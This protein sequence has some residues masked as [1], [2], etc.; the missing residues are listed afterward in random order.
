M[1]AV[2]TQKASM[3]SLKFC[4]ASPNIQVFSH[5]LNNIY[6]VGGIRSKPISSL[7]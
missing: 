6:F 1:N 5:A 2:D 3:V 7:N 4:F